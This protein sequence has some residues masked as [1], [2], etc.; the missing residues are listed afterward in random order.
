[1]T[2]SGIGDLLL[3]FLPWH[4]FPIHRST[5]LA[6]PVLEWISARRLESLPNLTLNLGFV[7]NM[8]RRQPTPP[9]ACP[10]LISLQ[11]PRQVGTTVFPFGHRPRKEEFNR[12]LDLH[13]HPPPHSCPWRIRHLLRFGN[14]RSKLLALLQSALFHDFGLFPQATSLITLPIRLRLRT[15]FV[16]PAALS[17]IA[18]NFMPGYAQDWSFNIQ[19]E[20]IKLG[21]FSIAYAG[22]KGTHLPRSLD[23]N[24]PLPWLALSPREPYPAYSNMLM[25]ESGGDSEYESLQF[26]STVDGEAFIDDRRL[27][28]LEIDGRYFGVSTHFDR[29]KL[30]AR[31]P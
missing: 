25:T 7:T 29:P 11:G 31:Q 5:N 26:P 4:P 19:Q 18:P 13:G 24:Q 16:P 10:P 1:M 2:G 21:V 6:F 28:F 9:I 15:G 12:V 23:I 30:S 17:F 8:T 20:W 27:Y 22:A 3:G 14:V